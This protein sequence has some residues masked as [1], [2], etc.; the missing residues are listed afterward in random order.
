M[1]PLEAVAGPGKAV[2]KL[3][4][5]HPSMW[6]PMYVVLATA[7]QELDVR[8]MLNVNLGG[9]AESEA[10]EVAVK[11]KGTPLRLAVIM[12]TPAACRRN[13]SRNVPSKAWSSVATAIQLPAARV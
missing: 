10:T 4:V 1:I 7:G 12:A 3:L 2:R 13:I 9:F 6:T 5:F 11:P 8:A